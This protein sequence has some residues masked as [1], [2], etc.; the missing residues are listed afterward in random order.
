MK[1]VYL[2]KSNRSNPNLVLKVRELLSKF[3]IEIIEFTGGEYTHK[4][5][6]ECDYLIVIPELP[7]DNLDFEVEN[8]IIGNGLFSQINVFYSYLEDDEYRKV[9]I[10]SDEYLQIKNIRE[11]KILDSNNYISTAKVYLEQDDFYDTL[12][13]FCT[14]TFYTSKNSNSSSELKSI[15]QTN[16]NYIYAVAK[17]YKNVKKT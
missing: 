17:L 11:I 3:D 6:L 15:N 14:D 10:I 16:I 7:K 5:L 8:V 2:A 1:K 4:P 13:E 12:E 9:I